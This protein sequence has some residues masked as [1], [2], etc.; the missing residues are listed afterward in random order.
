LEIRLEPG[1]ILT[2][3]AGAYQNITADAGI[4]S[5]RFPYFFPAMKKVTKKSPLPERSLELY[6]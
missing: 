1:R 5:E 4:S 2:I 6:G 3:E